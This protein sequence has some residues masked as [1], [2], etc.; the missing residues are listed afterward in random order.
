LK[1]HVTKFKIILGRSGL[2][3][4][5][6]SIVNPDGKKWLLLSG[7][8]HPVFIAPKNELK[9]NLLEGSHQGVIKMFWLHFS[10]REWHTWTKCSALKVR[11]YV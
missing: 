1:R 2:P 11:Y 3:D 4:Y 10:E 9:P 7:K 6:G 5:T 8:S